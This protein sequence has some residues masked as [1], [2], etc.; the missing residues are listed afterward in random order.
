MPGFCWGGPSGPA[1]VA[2]PRQCETIF[3]LGSTTGAGQKERWFRE[4]LDFRRLNL[5]TR[6]DSFPIPR[7][8]DCLDA[9]ESA[10]VFSTSDITSAY[11]Q[12]PV[13]EQDIPKTA[14]ISKYGLFEFTTMPF[15]LC[16][17]AATFQKL[18]EVALNGLQWITCLIYL[19]DVIIFSASFDDHLVQL[20]DVLA[21]T[22][23]AG[24]KLKPRKCHFF[25]EEVAF[26]GHLVSSN[27]VLPHPGNSNKLVEW[28]APTNV[29]EV[30][31]IL[32][33][34]NYYR[35][36]VRDF[37]K[38]VQPLIKL[39]KKDT[40]FVWTEATQAAFERLKEVLLISPDVMAFPSESGQYI[41][42]KDASDK[43]IGAILS[44]VQEG[45]ERVI[46]FGSHMLN[47]AERNY[48]VTDRELL[49]VKFFVDQYKHYLLGRRFL[50]RTDHQ[51][52]RWLFSLK[53]TKSRVARWIE[54]LS[55]YD[56]EIEYRPEKKHS[57]ADA[58][59]RCPNPR[60]CA[61]EE[62]EQ[63]LECGLCDKCLRK[64]LS[65]RAPWFKLTFQWGKSLVRDSL[66]G[67]C[68]RCCRPCGSS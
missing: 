62:P 43:T 48:C 2:S 38:I 14:F 17:S 30:R 18:T 5:A 36:F 58:L 1:K 49:S 26:L 68:G 56:F 10:K 55:A 51:A 47:R 27:G 9:L 13:R 6:K 39:T 8:Q 59:S 19:D 66:S 41:L 24:L 65:W 11:N 61:C 37:S 50:I 33:L 34:G 7:T 22:A 57:N 25:E 4:A 67:P 63:L 31:G 29:T 20:S 16:N 32:G 60:Q 23:D 21:R 64:V 15:G 12:I 53:E 40:L 3:T 52:L 42:D 54:L 46:A 35:R 28:P 44:Q 45:R